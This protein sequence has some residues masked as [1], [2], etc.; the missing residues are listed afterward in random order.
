MDLEHIVL[1]EIKSD[2]EKQVLIWY[3]LHVKSKRA[4]PVKTEK[5]VATIV[6]TRLMVCK[7]TA[8]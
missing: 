8:L 5:M 4:K 2:K 3:Y 6:G 1:S 7:A